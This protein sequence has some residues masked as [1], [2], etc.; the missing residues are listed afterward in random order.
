MPLSSDVIQAWYT[1]RL[2]DFFYE[3]YL[4]HRGYTAAGE[5]RTSDPAEDVYPS[6]IELSPDANK[7]ERDT[8]PEA[9]CEAYDYYHQHFA[10]A[11]IGSP[12]IY[13]V[14]VEGELT[15]AVRT[16]TDGDDGYLEVFDEQG[17]LLACGRTNLE[18]VAWGSRDWLRDQVAKLGEFPPEMKDAAARTS[19]GKPLPWDC[20]A[21][22]WQCHASGHQG[23]CTHKAGHRE[24]VGDLHC[25]NASGHTWDDTPPDPRV[26]VKPKF[27]LRLRDG[28]AITGTL[29]DYKLT[30]STIHGPI[31]ILANDLKKIDF[32]PTN[33]HGDT[34]RIAEA[35][36]RLAGDESADA[37]AELLALGA[38]AF[39]AVVAV[40]QM[41]DDAIHR[42]AR[43]VAAQIYQGVPAE[44]LSLRKQHVV[45]TRDAT[46]ACAL[47]PFSFALMVAEGYQ[48]FE[49]CDLHTL[50]Q[51][52]GA[53]IDAPRENPRWLGRLYTNWFGARLTFLVTGDPD[54]GEVFGSDPYT[55]DSHLATAAVHAGLVKPGETKTLRVEIILSPPR[56][57]GSEQNGV[58]SLDW[59]E[60]TAGAFRF[61]D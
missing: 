8:V 23:F 33:S 21:A 34:S 13:A 36:H 14:A 6:P 29:P 4:V 46:I 30:L 38:R 35:V 20:Q 40:A 48:S 32:A 59:D 51:L 15:Y 3:R 11:D 18:V 2:R 49:L 16:T 25:C 47:D 9:V 43:A 1:Q 17:A 53:A 45:T 26:F 60:P 37:E 54:D 5:P 42:R 58:A 55:L 10:E 50:T 31:T 44:F 39:Q 27:E 41:G 24:A 61:I 7:V 56:F 22:C 57:A 52:P 12:R 19:W 28:T